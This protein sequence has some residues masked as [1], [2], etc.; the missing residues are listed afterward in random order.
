V[1]ELDGLQERLGLFEVDVVG[2]AELGLEALAG[3]VAASSAV[4]G[5]VGSSAVPSLPQR[6]SPM[7]ELSGFEIAFSPLGTWSVAS[8][9]RY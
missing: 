5:S 4:P 3:A 2:P 1:P 7:P 8:I 9:K 6:H